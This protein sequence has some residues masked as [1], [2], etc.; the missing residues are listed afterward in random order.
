MSLGEFEVCGGNVG[1][2]VNH[3]LKIRGKNI[4]IH[5]ESGSATAKKAVKTQQKSKIQQTQQSAASPDDIG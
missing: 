1:F 4:S 3:G 2:V 5:E